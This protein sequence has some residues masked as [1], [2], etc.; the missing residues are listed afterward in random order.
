MQ[1]VMLFQ[2]QQFIGRDGGSQM[3][4]ALP[5]ILVLIQGL[6]GQALQQQPPQRC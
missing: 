1:Q 4:H 6:I 3:H 5:G 2:R